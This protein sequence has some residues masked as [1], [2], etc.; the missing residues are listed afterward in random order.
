MEIVRKGDRRTGN[1][2]RGRQKDKAIPDKA[3]P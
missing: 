2:Y 1:S 3:V